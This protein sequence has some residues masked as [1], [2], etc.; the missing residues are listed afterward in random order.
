CVAMNKARGLT[1]SST[2]Q[3]PRIV[4]NVFRSFVGR[5][6]RPDLRGLRSHF[7]AGTKG[8][9]GHASVDHATRQR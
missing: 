7:C 5:V 8:K 9:H 2:V 4:G 3:T 6:R 1:R